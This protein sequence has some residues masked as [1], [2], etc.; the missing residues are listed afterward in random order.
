MTEV[1]QKCIS[2]KAAAAKLATLGSR[3]KDA[4]LLAM[5]DAF[6][7]NRDI[8]FEAN[9]RDLVAAESAG[10]SGAMLKAFG[11]DR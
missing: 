3:V 2:A 7:A 10:L 11:T 4:A 1:T 6:E 8:I 5:A 9:K